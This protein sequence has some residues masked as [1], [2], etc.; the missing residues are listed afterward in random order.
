MTVGW[1][2]GWM[3]RWMDRWMDGWV[4]DHRIEGIHQISTPA[5]LPNTLFPTALGFIPGPPVH[6]KR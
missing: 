6:G 2:D 1:M 3:D 4:N 5:S